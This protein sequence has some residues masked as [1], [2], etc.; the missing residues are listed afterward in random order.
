MTYDGLF[1]MMIYLLLNDSSMEYWQAVST[2]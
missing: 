2:A 1:P